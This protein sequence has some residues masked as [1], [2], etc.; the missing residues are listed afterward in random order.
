MAER[1]SSKGKDE[2]PRNRF[3]LG[4]PPALPPMPF[5]PFVN[6][7]VPLSDPWECVTAVLMLPLVLCRMSIFVGSFFCAY[8][9]ANVALIG[10][11]N[12]FTK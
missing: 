4:P 10:A 5:N 9:V 7:S 3:P 2:R 8:I 6:H 11:R 12:V 1:R